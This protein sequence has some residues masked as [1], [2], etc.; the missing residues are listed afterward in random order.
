MEIRA[1]FE[2]IKYLNKLIRQQRTGTPE[3]LAKKMQISVATLYRR[4][5]VLKEAGVPIKYYRNL[6]RYAY[7]D[8]DF[9]L[10]I[11]DFLK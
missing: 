7:T 6:Q 5:R 2:Q 3:Q 9:I 11:E 1:Y 8:K 10:D 4:L